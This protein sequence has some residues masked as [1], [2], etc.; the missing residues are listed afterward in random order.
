MCQSI[1]IF[2]FVPASLTTEYHT[3]W[4]SAVGCLLNQETFFI[5]LGRC[6]QG[7]PLKSPREKQEMFM[8]L[9]LLII[10]L[11]LILN[12]LIDK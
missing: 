5:G 2:Q 3:F 10:T 4:R 1:P 11:C 6:K 7:V 9:L 12:V 8:E